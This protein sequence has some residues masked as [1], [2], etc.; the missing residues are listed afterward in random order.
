MPNEIAVDSAIADPQQTL[1]ERVSELEEEVRNLLRL[2]AAIERN[3][4][5]FEALL[6]SSR[7]GITLTR[8]DGTIIKVVRGILGYA[9]DLSGASVYDIV[10]PEDREAMRAAYRQLVERR[11]R[12]VEIEFH[13]YAADGSPAWIECTMTDML[14]D[15]AVLAI[16]LNYR[17]V[18]RLKASQFAEAEFEAAIRFAPFAVFSKNTSGEILTWNASARELFG[19]ERDE[20]VG[21]H[22]STLIPPEL[23]EEEVHHRSF[24]VERRTVKPGIRTVGVRKDGRRLLLEVVLSPIVVD[25]GVRGIAQLSYPLE[26]TTPA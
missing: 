11:Q 12:R 17:N 24:V 14:D 20:I 7:D 26:Q 18:T 19:Y 8:C 23:R 9:K 25:G 21:S 10:Y 1:I 6:A 2:H 3:N 22:I 4:A 13:M 16:V 5:L 15:P